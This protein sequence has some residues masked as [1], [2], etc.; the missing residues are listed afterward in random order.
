MDGDPD[1]PPIRSGRAVVATLIALGALHSLPAHGAPGPVAEKTRY[2]EAFQRFGVSDGLANNLVFGVAQDKY[3]FLWATTRNGISKFDGSDFTV[4]RP[5][6]PG[7]KRQVAQFYQTIYQSRDGSLWFCSWGNGLLRLDI[8]T[9]QFT[10]F[11]HDDSKPDSIAGNNVWFAFEDRGGMMWVSS[12][13]G[14]SRL[15]PKTGKATVYRHDPKQPDSLANPSPTQVVQDKDGMLWVGTYGGGL[16]RLD[17][18]TGKFS[19][20]RHDERNPNSLANDSVEGLYLDD[21]GTLWIATDGGLNHFDPKS[22]RFI[23]FQHDP[24]DPGSL[25]NN[26]VLK[27]M[28]DSRGQLWTSN[29]GG[30]VQRMDPKTGKFIHYRYSPGDPLSVASNLTEYMIEAQD[31]A[32]WIPTFNGLVRYDEESGRFHSSLQQTGLTA[33]SG[34][35]LVSGM[36]QDR[37]G[38]LWVVSEDSGA[39]RYD[40]GMQST[41]HYLPQPGNPRSLSEVAITALVCD[42]DGTIWLATRA[43]LDR[44]DE[45]TDGFER[46]KLSRYAP[47]GMGAAADSTISDM[48][49]DRDGVLWMAVYGVGLQRFDPKQK[50][51]TLYEHNPADPSS[52]GNNLTNA[53]LAASDGSVWV[54]A[55]AGLSRLDPRTG[56]FTNFSEKDGLSSLIANDLAE[57]ADG[58]VLIATDV[59]VNLYDPRTGKF[60]VFTTQQGMPSNYVMSLEGDADGNIWAGTDKGLVRITPATGKVRAYDARD[61]LPSNQFW[62]HSVYRAPDGTMYFG[63]TNGLTTFRPDTFKD[64]ADPP[65]V[66]ITE[67]SLFK[68]KVVAGPDSPLRASVHLTREITL[69]HRQSSLGFKFAALNYRWPAKN[70]Y[71]YQ[72][73]GFDHGWTY[74]DSAHR[75]AAYTNLAPGNYVFRVK[76]SNNDG[77]WNETGAALAITITP[78]WWQTWTF[79]VVMAL[80]GAALIHAL[81]RVRVHQLEAQARKLQRTV[82]E[83]THDLQIAKEKAEIANQ[84]KSTFLANMSHELRTP[85]NAILGYAQILRR[86]AEQLSRRHAS[87]LATIQDSGQHLLNLINDILDLARIEAGKLSLYPTDCNVPALL[88]LVSKIIRVKSEEK[89]LSFRCDAAPDLPSDVKADDKRLRQVLLNLLCNAVK[90]TDRGEVSLRVLK[91]A[92]TPAQPDGE[93]GESGTPDRVRLRFEVQDTG[94]GMDDEQMAYLFKRFEQVG[95]AQRREGGSG[96][97]LAISQQLIR[98]M[99]GNIEVASQPGKG[100][101]FWFELDL[102]VALVKRTFQPTQKITGYQGPRKKLLVVD[103][104]PQNRVLLIDALH[105]L[106]F[107]VVDAENG[108]EC[109]DLLDAVNPDLIVMDVMMP[110][111]DGREA[112]RRIRKRPRFAK[113]PIIASSASATREDEML[114]YEAG[115]DVFV[116]KPIDNDALLKIIG[117]R[118]SLA[119]MTTTEPAPGAPA[120][121]AGAA[122]D[123]GLVVLPEDEIEALYQLAMVGNMQSLCARADYLKGLDARYGAFAQQ[124]RALAESYQSKAILALVGRLR[125]AH[126]AAQAADPQP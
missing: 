59:G 116:P 105:P 26:A 23:L 78:P 83:R 38:R 94:I 107:D 114:C 50:R 2:N 22:G 125:K 73:E 43:G 81:Y 80:L 76:A 15:D 36:A 121:G 75:E 108:Q 88:D 56:K 31:H 87:G 34:R 68:H 85:L 69:D 17:P 72:L 37:R 28:R 6:P 82:D 77:V 126:E 29:W 42:P 123:A 60:T 5:V 92:H 118:L 104:V 79:R 113:I 91:V 21:D 8:A 14:L 3:G 44:Y 61:G 57:L 84:V 67:L 24:N 63:T 70:Q 54:A 119:W 35:M 89:S 45:R 64:N 53:V 49:A 18:A 99:G 66:Y 30:G 122:Q 109:L 120:P 41:H 46:I 58:T 112:T 110:V 16:D 98:M 7:A 32:F 102:P 9:E 20:Y 74:V 33:T 111:M 65:P 117:E 27:V 103:D 4:Y 13:G 124:L 90:F 115:A 1:R 40:P 12:A 19:H 97:G 71:A 86:D 39:T 11:V 62:N 48:V 10:F 106:G 101:L 52:L 55:D 95:D 51:L 47:P 100:S 96:L 93:T 25:S